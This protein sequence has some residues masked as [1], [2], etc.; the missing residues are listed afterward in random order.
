MPTLYTE[1][2]EKWKTLADIDYFTQFVKAWIPFN[3]WYKN[4]YPTLDTDKAAID[5]IKSTNNTV[6]NKLISL[7]NG[8]DTDSIAFR[9]HLAKLHS[10]LGRKY[11]FNKYGERI[12]FDLIV[13]E[14]NPE[15]IIIYERNSII[16]KV[17][18]G[19][20]GRSE[21]EIISTVQNKAR[22]M[23][24]T[25]TQSDGYNLEDLKTQPGFERLSQSQ[26]ASLE[27]AYK[28]ANPR[29]P[30][31]LLTNDDD[32]CIKVG[33]I[34]FITDTTSL[35]K[36]ILEILYSLRNGLFHGEIVPDKE[37]NRVYESAYHILNALVQAL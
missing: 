28:D 17:E 3:A 6:R 22:A 29:R 25:C 16:C 10:E 20:G 30:I 33:S 4:Y 23:V 2:S 36:G 8:N 11:I 32:H 13:I 12:C 35:S 34:K 19:P 1:N 24:F 14:R 7:L 9:S 21:K 18:R 15:K 27:S 37:T 5:E 26:K 31:C